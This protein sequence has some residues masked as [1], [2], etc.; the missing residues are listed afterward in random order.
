MPFDKEN[1]F[2]AGQCRAQEAITLNQAGEVEKAFHAA[3]RAVLQAPQCPYAH[4]ILG[5]IMNNN[6][7][8]LYAEKHIRESKLLGDH[9]AVSEMQ[10]GYSFI[11]SGKIDAA[12]DAFTA[13]IGVNV[14]FLPAH[15][16]LAKVCEIRGEL[17]QART[18]AENVFSID[19]TVPT[20]R[21][22][23][24]QILAQLGEHEKAIGVLTGPRMDF[25]ALYERGKL[26]ERIGSYDMAWADYQEANRLTGKV[27]D[28]AEA[29]LRI[30]NHKVFTSRGQL[31]RL[32]K[33]VD[34]ASSTMPLFITGYPRSGTTLLETMLSAHGD[35]DAGD[36]LRFLHNIAGFCQ[37]WL[38][39]DQP[40]PFALDELSIGD[41]TAVLGAFRS[42]YLAKVADINPA[43]TRFVTD[44]MPMNEMHLPLISILFPEAPTL[45]IRRHPLDIIVSNF[46]TYLTH[47][48]NQ[49]FDLVSCATHYAR[50]DDLLQH[51]LRKVEMN[52]REINYEAMIA[53]PESE[54][55]PVLAGMGLPWR[56]ACV[57]PEL[58]KHHAR[59]PSYAAVKKPLNDKSIGRWKNFEKY[60]GPIM[61]IVE[62]IMER[63][64]Y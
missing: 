60:L 12:A 62:P 54:I 46:S 4:G 16:G 27:Y 14:N 32:P 19:P 25:V 52:F 17:D 11:A 33:L 53:A 9:P 59:T 41:K 34:Q 24:A 57:Q 31:A 36:E 30:N 50:V 38:G 49:S 8:A 44:K 6:G 15:V 40:Y 39:S 5:N 56:K 20:V 28:D 21:V 13:S 22:V 45:Y 64:G 55:R 48:F 3:R 42:Y 43:G 29:M 61:A 35:I 23:Y 63:E 18:L 7:N 47:G 1:C 51:Y 58:N 2:C 37:A 10:L 26:Y